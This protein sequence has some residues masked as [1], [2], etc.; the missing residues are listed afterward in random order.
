L[1]G[2]A[3]CAA[4]SGNQGGHLKRPPHLK[5]RAQKTAPDP[6]EIE[7]FRREVSDA[8]PLAPRNKAKL[9]KPHSHG[10]AHR[11]RAHATAA[12]A[13]SD[14]IPYEGEPGEPLGFSRSGV[15]R[16]TLRQLRRGGSEI[17]DELDLHGLTVAAA[18][19]LLISFLNACRRRGYTRVRMIHGRG[20]RSESGEGVLKR[21][22]AGWLAQREDVL[23]FCEAPPAEGGAGAV[24]VLLKR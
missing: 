6:A 14:H 22:V 16:S 12:D 23:A 10:A 3:R 13:L 18:K 5:P 19:P 24:I 2:R 1:H 9:E 11:A 17:E 7:L 15:R 20:L 8:T 4:L 21:M